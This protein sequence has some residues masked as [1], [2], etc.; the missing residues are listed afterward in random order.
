MRFLRRSSHSCVASFYLCCDCMC[1]LLLN[2]KR[3]TEYERG[4]R[5]VSLVSKGKNG[6]ASVVTI[7]FCVL[8]E[9]GKARACWDNLVSYPVS[10]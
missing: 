6:D 10:C 5:K 4:A 7:C 3:C 9:V 2:C 8:Q 1:K